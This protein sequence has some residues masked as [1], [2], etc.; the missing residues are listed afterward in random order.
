MPTT[1]EQVYNVFLH[2]IDDDVLALLSPE[3]VE[4]MLL[5]YL[6]GACTE[7][8]TCEKDLTI[9]TVAK[10]FYIELD[11]DEIYIL[12]RGMIMYWLQPKILREDTLR[13]M[14]TDKDYTQYSPA[15]MLEKLTK[16]K[17]VTEKDLIRRRT[18]YTYRNFKGFN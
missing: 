2:N 7:F 9:D 3:V 15:N 14:I 6:Q 4:D 13:N 1:L 17:E 16:L 18:K 10:A 11:M 5:I 8:T 12:A